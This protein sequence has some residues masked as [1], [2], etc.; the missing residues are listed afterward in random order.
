MKPLVHSYF[1]EDRNWLPEN[2]SRRQGH[3]E[4]RT[5][6]ARSKIVEKAR[7]LLPST[8]GYRCLKASKLADTTQSPCMLSNPRRAHVNYSICLSSHM[9]RLSLISPSSSK[10]IDCRWRLSGC[11]CRL[12]PRT[13]LHIIYRLQ[14]FNTISERALSHS[15]ACCENPMST[16][17]DLEVHG[18]TCT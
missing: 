11:G 14:K 18:L 8:P 7:A 13:S 9:P 12:T 1:K 10:K 3:C 4:L 2:G 6:E 15:G 5:P 17:A 16:C